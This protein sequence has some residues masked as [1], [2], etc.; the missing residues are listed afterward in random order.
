MAKR[1]LLGKEARKESVQALNLIANFIAGTLGPAGRPILMSK[2]ENGDKVPV[3]VTKDGLNCLHSLAFPDPVEEGILALCKQSAGKSVVA[4]GD[5][6]TSTIKKA[7]VFA[8]EIA[9]SKNQNPQSAIRSFRKEV[10]AAIAAIEKEA[11]ISKEATESVILTS[12]NHDKE[13]ASYVSEAIGNTSAYG[14][15]MVISSP[16]QVE[17]YK[18]DKDFGYECGRGYAFSDMLAQSINPGLNPN[19]DLIVSSPHVIPFNGDIVN[20]SQIS[21]IMNNLFNQ[22]NQGQGNFSVLI[23]AHQIA[24]G[25]AQEVAMMNRKWEENVKV[26]IA[27]VQTTNTLE[28][29]GSVEQLKDIAAFSGSMIYDGGTVGNIKADKLGMI[30]SVRIQPFKSFMNGKSNGNRIKERARENSKTAKVA[31]CEMDRE[32][33]NARNASLTNGLVKLTV[34]GAL[35]SELSEIKDRAEDAIKAGQACNRSGA[36]PGCGVS[37]IRAGKLANVSQPIMN[38]L[39]SIHYAILSNYGLEEAFT[40][41]HNAGET[42]YVSDSD[43]QIGRNFLEVG[44]ADSFETIKGVITNAFE[45]GALVANLGGVCLEADLEEIRRAKMYVDM[46]NGVS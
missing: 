20:I 23:V 29:N 13:M 26:K 36:L 2:R 45:L 43:V 22:I 12:T 28:V 39:S 9:E 34:G 40:L 35:Y 8:H 41:N 5:G 38:A 16:T 6:T 15:I 31:L 21:T 11:V 7:S 19:Q 3:S 33:A 18:I 27:M 17:R 24:T 46:E 42:V 10:Q 44:V 32:F 37:Y 4:S 25:V 30:G 14:S 1:I